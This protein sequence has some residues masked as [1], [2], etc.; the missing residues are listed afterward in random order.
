MYLDIGIVSAN[1]HS[2]SLT[3]DA[4]SHLVH[5][6]LYNQVYKSTCMLDS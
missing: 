2:G 3:T 4:V 1:R 6:F 5:S